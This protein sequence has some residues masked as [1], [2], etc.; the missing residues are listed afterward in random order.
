MGANRNRMTISIDT[1]L[2]T[3]NRGLF[4]VVGASSANPPF[5]ILEDCCLPVSLLQ[6]LQRQEVGQG[7]FWQQ[8]LELGRCR[9]SVACTCTRITSRILAASFAYRRTFWS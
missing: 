6:A 4:L 3:L 1:Q 2:T 7:E 8:H 5:L 9:G